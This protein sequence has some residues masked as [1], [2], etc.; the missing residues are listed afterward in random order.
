MS[1]AVLQIPEQPGRFAYHDIV[2]GV[3]VE[4]RGGTATDLACQRHLVPAW[5]A[6]RPGDDIVE[7]CQRPAA[8]TQNILAGQL[9]PLYPDIFLLVLQLD[10]V[11]I[12]GVIIERDQ[13]REREWR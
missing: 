9:H 3:D 12:G 10:V 6:R 7:R 8:A 2:P 13:C 1:L 4:R 11:R 5:N